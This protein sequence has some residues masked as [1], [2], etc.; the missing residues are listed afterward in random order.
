MFL[1]VCSVQLELA[2]VIISR[3]RM[4]SKNAPAGSSSQIGFASQGVQDSIQHP[5]QHSNNTLKAS[6]EYIIT[7]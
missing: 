5:I 2:G 7:S 4:G 6:V 3:V 1:W